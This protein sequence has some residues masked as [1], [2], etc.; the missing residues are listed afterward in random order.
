MQYLIN[1]YTGNM[2]ETWRLSTREKSKGESQEINAR[3]ESDVSSLNTARI[4][5]RV[6]H[7]PINA[8]R[9]RL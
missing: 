6:L 3:E 5:V 2:P 1:N 7:F 8:M 4:I 9:K